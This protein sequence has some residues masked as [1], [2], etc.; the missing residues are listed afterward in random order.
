MSAVHDHADRGVEQ[1]YAISH[2]SEHVV[3]NSQCLMGA[4]VGNSR[5][6]YL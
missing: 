2:F 1:S 5:D 4:V 3:M 6:A